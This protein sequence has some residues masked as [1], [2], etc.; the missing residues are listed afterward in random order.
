VIIKV[1]DVNDNRPE[2][3]GNS[4]D[5]YIPPGKNKRGQKY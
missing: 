5:F 4:S 2:F 1:D 3:I